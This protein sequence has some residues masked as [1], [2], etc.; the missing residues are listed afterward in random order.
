MPE[1]YHAIIRHGAYH[2][3]EG[4]PSAR[5]PYALTDEGLVPWYPP[6]ASP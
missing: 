6:L 2:Q 1:S 4:A 3:R 5:Q